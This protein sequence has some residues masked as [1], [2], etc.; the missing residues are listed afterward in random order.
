VDTGHRSAG[1]HDPANQFRLALSTV[2]YTL[3]NALRRLGLKDTPLAKAHCSTIRTRLLKIGVRVV[4]TARK[5]WVSLSQSCPLPAV[6]A[7]AY[8]HLTMT[9]AVP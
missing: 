6:F 7:A 4:I 8:R 1:E 5:V 9:P 3:L 2:A